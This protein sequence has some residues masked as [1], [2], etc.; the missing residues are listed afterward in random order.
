MIE[1]VRAAPR[2]SVQLRRDHRTP[3]ERRTSSTHDAARGHR[4]E[5]RVRGRAQSLGVGH[6]RSLQP[7]MNSFRPLV[8]G[9]PND[10]NA[11]DLV[12]ANGN[13]QALVIVLHKTGGILHPTITGPPRC[14]PPHPHVPRHLPRPRRRATRGAD[15]PLDRHAA[16]SRSA[17]APAH[18]GARRWTKPGDLRR[19][20]SRWRRRIPPAA[21]RTSS[22]AIVC[23]KK[24]N[25]A[26]CTKA[27]PGAGPHDPGNGHA[28]RPEP[29]DR[30]VTGHGHHQGG[31]DTAAQSRSRPRPHPGTSTAERR[32]S[33]SPGTG[34]T[35]TTNDD[36]GTRSGHQQGG[37]K[38]GRAVSGQLLTA[39]AAFVV[40]QQRPSVTAAAA[41]RAPT[42]PR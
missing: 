3:A 37:P 2:A 39:S 6:D 29:T 42:E 1:N 26:T 13:R 35:S 21:S 41:P 22:V 8:A 23:P 38:A 15:V 4:S 30:P 28:R 17:P 31:H 9:D 5:Q 18:R 20:S 34:H 16:P 25:T 24:G 19:L 11:I 40:P 33:T 32:P 12:V 14:A 36:P 27:D 7:P 10:V